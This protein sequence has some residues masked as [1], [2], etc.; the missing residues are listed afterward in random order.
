MSVVTVNERL[1]VDAVIEEERRR[2]LLRRRQ[3][4]VEH[5]QNVDAR[6]MKRE[7]SAGDDSLMPSPMPAC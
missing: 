5:G 7:L 2:E 3:E 1:V 6:G 4:V